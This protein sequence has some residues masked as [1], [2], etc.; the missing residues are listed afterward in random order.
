MNRRSSFRIAT[1]KPIR[2]GNLEPCT[3][4]NDKLSNRP[5]ILHFAIR[6]FTKNIDPKNKLDSKHADIF[7]EKRL[8]HLLITVGGKGCHFYLET[9]YVQSLIQL[10][11]QT[12]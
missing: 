11:N 1:K 7:I 2:D 4:K 8:S 12:L 3:K 5:K 10:K 9:T 6:T